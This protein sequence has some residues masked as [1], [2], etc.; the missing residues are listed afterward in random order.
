MLVVVV[1]ERIYYFSPHS[2]QGWGQHLPHKGVTEPW[3]HLQ[4]LS[5]LPA[6]TRAGRVRGIG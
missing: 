1:T 3:R 5:L 6:P 2:Q 4:P